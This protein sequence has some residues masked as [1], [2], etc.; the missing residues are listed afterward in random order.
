MM[1][2]LGDEAQVEAQF[3]PFGESANLDTRWLNGLGRMYRRLKN[4][5]GRTRW[6]S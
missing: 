1:V 6:N 4:C 2:L 5:F 3:C